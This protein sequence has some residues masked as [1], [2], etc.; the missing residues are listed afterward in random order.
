MRKLKSVK[1]VEPFD[2]YDITVENDHCFELSNGIIAHNSSMYPR[3]ILSGGSGLKYAADIILFLSKKKFKDGDTVVGNIIHVVNHKNRLA[4]ENALVDIL[5]TYDKGLDRYY[6]LLD[7]AEK[8]N[9]FKKVSTRYEMPDGTKVFG[10]QINE[11]PEKYYTKEILDQL[12]EAAKQEF[13]YGKEVNLE[14][15]ESE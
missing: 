14:E 12:D 10:K 9:I 7:L 13:Q 6:G 11:N 8:Y 3:K 2:L 15:K 4:K 5:L 1:E